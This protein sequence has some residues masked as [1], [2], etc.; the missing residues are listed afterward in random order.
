MAGGEQPW[1]R[2]LHFPSRPH[3][4]GDARARAR[5]VWQARVRVRVHQRLERAHQ[6]QRLVGESASA[7]ATRGL[8]QGLGGVGV[9]LRAAACV[10]DQCGL[11]K[12][13]PGSEC[14]SGAYLQKAQCWDRT[15]PPELLSSLG[16]TCA[17]AA[18]AQP[19][20]ASRRALALAARPRDSRSPA[21]LRR[22]RKPDAAAVASL[23]HRVPALTQDC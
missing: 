21:L 11:S 9:S 15:R 4:G 14:A 12:T 10:R 20:A 19:W 8:S 16:P 23:L 7:A 3:G 6:P 2:V 13:V 5:W 1:W 18:A 17:A 22:G